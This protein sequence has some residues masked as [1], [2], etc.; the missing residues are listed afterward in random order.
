MI[1]DLH[2][3]SIQLCSLVR[4]YLS[5]GGDQKGLTAAQPAVSAGLGVSVGLVTLAAISPA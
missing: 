4:S 1:V 2:W 5:L 3:P